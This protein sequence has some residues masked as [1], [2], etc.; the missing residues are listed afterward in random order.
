M[1]DLIIERHGPILVLTINREGV[2]NA[3][4]AAS[5]AAID[6]QLNKADA[7]PEIGATILTAVG[8]K[9]FCS[10]MDMKEAAKIG[11]GHGLIPGR[12]FAGITSARRAKPLIAAVN[13][14]AVAGGME[15]ILACDMVFA[16]DHAVFGLSEV[17]RGLFAFAGGVQR[18]ARQVPRATGLRMILTGETVTAQRL[19]D[20][21]VITEV[22]PRQNLLARTLEVAGQML[23]HPWA[24]I[25]DAK[26]L[27]D[28][29]ADAVLD[30]SLNFGAAFGHATFRAAGTQD[31]VSAYVEGR[32]KPGA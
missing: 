25:R 9:A 31:G 24:A 11:I 4:N 7:D 26:L 20:L 2:R 12:G 1:E 10:G 8:E 3:L 21:G 15:I 19:Y 30:H 5:C 16:A 29:S 17:K 13:G 18:L 6:D 27:Y 28:F 23:Q 22:V 14:V 32:T